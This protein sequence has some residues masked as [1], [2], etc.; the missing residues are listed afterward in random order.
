MQKTELKGINIHIFTD[1]IEYFRMPDY[2]FEPL[3][4]DVHHYRW[5]RNSKT[6]VNN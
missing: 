2:P 5:L 4:E 1:P 6:R 3:P